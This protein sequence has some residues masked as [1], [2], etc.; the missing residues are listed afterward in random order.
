[1]IKLR[2]LIEFLSVLS[3][4]LTFLAG[5]LQQLSFSEGGEGEGGVSPCLQTKNQHVLKSFLLVIRHCG[6]ISA[7]PFTTKRK[8][9]T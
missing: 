9:D 5:E 2:F 8:R 7:I 4:K 3:R 1:M 6:A